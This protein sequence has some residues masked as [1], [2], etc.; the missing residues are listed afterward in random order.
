MA[1][2]FSRRLLVACDASGYSARDDIRQ[3]D[4]Q[5]HLVTVLDAAAHDAQL[6]RVRWRRQAAGDGELAV[7]P[8]DEDEARVVEDFVHKLASRVRRHNIT[9]KSEFRL[10]LRLAIHFGMVSPAANGFS[11]QGPVIVTR[12]LDSS[13]VRQALALSRADLAVVLSQHVY[14][15]TVLQRHTSFE[16]RDFR[17]VAVQAKNYTD[18]AWLWLSSGDAGSLD[19][20]DTSGEKPSPPSSEPQQAG[21]SAA[22]RE[23]APEQTNH[24]MHWEFHS[25]TAE[26]SHIGPVFNGRQ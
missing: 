6:D 20:D 17:R 24:S 11:G 7:L 2:S 26:N 3:D 23:P 15:D 4:L 8:H 9:L 18:F 10:R 1:Q 19:L 13:V 16:A 22:T 5:R 21:Q 25:V 14:N 12:L